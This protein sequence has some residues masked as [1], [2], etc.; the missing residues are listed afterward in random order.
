MKT[1]FCTSLLFHSLIFGGHSAESSN[2][3]APL[4]TERRDGSTLLDENFVAGHTQ[5]LY[6]SSYFAG[7]PVG[8][9]WIKA[10]EFRGDGFFGIGGSGTAFANISLSTSPKEIGSLSPVYAENIGADNMLFFGNGKTV[11]GSSGATLPGPPPY[12]TF[13]IHFEAEGK[14]FYY[15]P[16]KGSLLMDLTDFGFSPHGFVWDAEG[17]PGASSLTSASPD[18]QNPFGHLQNGVLVANFIYAVPEPSTFGL[19]AMTGCGLLV[20]RFRSHKRKDSDVP[21]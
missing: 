11:H 7:L 21:V 6:D 19:L 5:F 20:F 4:G 8:G 13:G 12:N 14:G 15:D 9:V 17:T 1:V 16:A 2:I 18:P 10:I 3:V